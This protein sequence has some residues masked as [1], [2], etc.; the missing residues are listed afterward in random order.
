MD[1]KKLYLQQ[2]KEYLKHK[3]IIKGGSSGICKQN[4]DEGDNVYN[5]DSSTFSNNDEP[6]NTDIPTSKECNDPSHIDFKQ[7]G[8]LD[9]LELVDKL[10]NY[11]E[12]NKILN[13][14]NVDLSSKLEE[15][16]ASLKSKEI[17]LEECITSLKSQ[18]DGYKKLYQEQRAEQNEEILKLKSFIKAQNYK[19]IFDMEEK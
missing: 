17:K 1:Y 18:D 12:S 15:Y 3:H 8:D 14:V 11:E 5:S 2:K 6:I 19:R 7:Y 10:N 13:N 9:W 4:P 16:S